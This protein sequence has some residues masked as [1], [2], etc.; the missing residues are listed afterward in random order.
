MLLD[1]NTLFVHMRVFDGS[2][3]SIG[4]TVS[5]GLVMTIDHGIGVDS[6][7]GADFT[8]H[9]SSLMLD[10]SSIL[11]ERQH[12]ILCEIAN[13]PLSICSPIYIANAG[14]FIVNEVTWH[15]V[16]GVVGVDMIDIDVIGTGMVHRITVC[17]LVKSLT[18][19]RGGVMFRNGSWYQIVNVT[20]CSRIAVSSIVSQT[21]V[22]HCRL[23]RS[24]PFANNALDSK[25][26]Q[27]Q[28]MRISSVL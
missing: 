23:D 25:F 27:C 24:K 10:R 21:L 28:E 14:G 12:V 6:T 4:C 1:V 3:M 2:T 5:I 8:L 13:R 20:D 17:P 18:R 26:L 9:V 22:R 15:I 11:T 7:L 19:R 16:I